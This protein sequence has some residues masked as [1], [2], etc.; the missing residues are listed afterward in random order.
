MIELRT[1]IVTGASKGIGRAVTKYLVMMGYHVLA[2]ARTEVLLKSLEDEIASIKTE[3]SVSICIADVCNTESFYGE[4][5]AFVERVGGLGLLF[6]NAAYNKRGTSEI[7]DEELKKILDVNIIG[8]INLIKFS[9]PVM[10]IQ[11]RGHIVNMSS[12]NAK[13]PR[14]FLGGY[15]ASKAALLAFNESLYKELKNT[16]IKVTALCPGFVDTEMTSGLKVDRDD[17]IKLDDICKA[18]EF[19]LSLSSS[20]AIKELCFES[21]IQVGGYC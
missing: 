8:A 11:K 21:S 10:R 13:V 20:V 18:L 2:I 19:I 17:L 16:G 6:N 15:A 3:G 1:A 9:V 5:T 12:R 14:E 4:A 7:D